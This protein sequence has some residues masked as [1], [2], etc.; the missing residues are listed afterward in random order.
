MLEPPSTVDAMAGVIDLDA[1]SWDHAPV[2]V[3]HRP[4][5]LTGLI[6]AALVLAL[7]TGPTAVPPSLTLAWRL[8]TSTPY[9]WLSGDAVYTIDAGPDVRLAAHDVGS[10]RVTWAVPLP[11]PLASAYAPNAAL[12]MTRFPPRLNDGVRTSVLWSDAARP[13]LTFPA[14]AM[15]LVH[16]TDDLAIVIDR[17]ETD[18]QPGYTA[19]EQ[20]AGLPWA[21]RVTAIDLRSGAVRWTRTISSGVRWS[22]PGVRP[23]SVGIVGLPAGQDWMVTNSSAGRVEVWDLRTGAV[24]S[25]RDLGELEPESYVVALADAVLLRHRGAAGPTVELLDPL[26]LDPRW[27]FVP[28]LPEAEPLSCAP[29]I[30]L[31]SN[32]GVVLVDPRTGTVVGRVTGTQLRPGPAGRLLV[33]GY[34]N[35]LSIV[36]V[37]DGRASTLRGWRGVDTGAYTAEAVV[38]RDDGRGWATVGL[39]QVATGVIRQLGE[40]APWSA[41][42]RCQAYPGHIACTDGTVL[43]VWRV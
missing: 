27:Q 22:M 21:H 34:G 13:S 29:A 19:V 15:P 41:G 28:V 26:T 18:S 9:A 10:A 31:S 23:G 17:D 12:L 39:L 1:A 43:S 16:I 32:G 7:L 3:R 2:R 11:G 5:A 33:T 36:D 30:C 35:P 38:A 37:S 42:N 25:R 4:P 8:E 20:A 24:R 6:L 14:V 40:A